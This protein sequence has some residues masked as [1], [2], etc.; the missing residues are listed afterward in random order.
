MMR[1]VRSLKSL[2]ERARNDTGITLAE[3]I[4]SMA[5]TTLILTAVSM[6]LISGY[7]ANTAATRS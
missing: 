4:V 5:L 1:A 2:R 6:L 3:L 7:R